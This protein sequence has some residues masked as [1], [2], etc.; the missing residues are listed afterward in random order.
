MEKFAMAISAEKIR[1]AIHGMGGPRLVHAKP[2]RP[3]VSRGA[4][5]VSRH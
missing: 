4:T 3:M 2:K 1:G 5:G